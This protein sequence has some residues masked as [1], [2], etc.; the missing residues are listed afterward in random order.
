MF[1]YLSGVL[2]LANVV[3]MCLYKPGESGR[4]ATLRYVEL[5]FAALFMAEVLLRMCA[6]GATL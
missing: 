4:N 1:H 2:V 3:V 5:A 6:L